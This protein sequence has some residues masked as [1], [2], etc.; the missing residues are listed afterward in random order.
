MHPVSALIYLCIKTNKT[1]TV[2][3]YTHIEDLKRYEIRKKT[4]FLNLFLLE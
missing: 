3:L 4:Y 1:K 2:K